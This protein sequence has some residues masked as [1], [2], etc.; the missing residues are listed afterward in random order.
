MEQR[1]IS[2]LKEEK[3]KCILC[4]GGYCRK[5][6]IKPRDRKQSDIVVCEECGHIQM[7]PLLSQQEEA[8]EYN[9][10]KTVRFSGIAGG[11]DFD[12][13]RTKFHE[14][15]KQHAEMYYP[16]LQ[17]HRN[18]LELASGYGFFAEYLNA[19]PDRKFNIE[20]VE[21]GEFRL[22]NYVGGTVY[23]LNFYTDEVP[24]KMR[25]KYD[26]I[27]CM[28]L[29]EHLSEPVAYLKAIKPLLS[30]DGEVLFEVPNIDCFLAELSS[31]YKDF[32]Y[33]YE[34]V[35]YYNSDTLRKVFELAG[36]EIKSIYTKE[37]YSLENHINWIRTGKPFTK[38]NQ[39]FMS[40]ERIEFINQIYKEKIGEMG[41]GYSLICEAKP[42]R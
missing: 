30:A 32:C 9:Q 34:H 18:V 17:R 37:I 36:Y 29:L 42:K 25:G 15:T 39:M 2:I 35:S 28:H 11:S 33:I 38:Y 19:K 7:Y 26:F 12:A 13:M 27:I 40:D 21:I 20:G 1:K 22:K 3:F 24:V 31:D 5:I 23:N 6:G 10:D 14:W 41:K 4:A 16:I 8:E